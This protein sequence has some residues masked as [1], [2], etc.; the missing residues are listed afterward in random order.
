MVSGTVCP[1]DR[2]TL[3]GMDERLGL[4]GPLGEML[5]PRLTVPE[6]PPLLVRVTEE[7]PFMP[8]L[9]HRVVG[10][11]L[12]LKSEFWPATRD[13]ETMNEL[14]TTSERPRVVISSR[15]RVVSSLLN[16]VIV[17]GQCR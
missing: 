5:A 9:T 17:D 15:F 3:D 13:A 2:L 16:V 7:A 14:S 8:G 11:A 4:L 6:N 12:R 10:F 1:L